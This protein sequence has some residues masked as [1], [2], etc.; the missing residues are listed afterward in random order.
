MTYREKLHPLFGKHCNVHHVSGYSQLDGVDVSN[1]ASSEDGT[2][3]GNAGFGD[4][5][6]FMSSLGG[7][8]SSA[9]ADDASATAGDATATDGGLDDFFGNVQKTISDATGGTTTTTSNQPFQNLKNMFGSTAQKTPTPSPAA[10]SAPAAKNAR[11]PAPASK[12]VDDS[13]SST[14]STSTTT[15]THSKADGNIKT[16]SAPAS[17]AGVETSGGPLMFPFGRMMVVAA[18]VLG[19]S[20]LLARF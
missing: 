19:T 6:S 12:M 4:L 20:M 13:S 1:E 3:A 9:S 15:T 5:Q 16:A 18:I 17:P 8:G 14:I 2:V 10:K 11:T 7:M